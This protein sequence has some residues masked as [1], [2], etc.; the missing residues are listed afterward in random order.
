[1]IRIINLISLT[2]GSLSGITVYNKQEVDYKLLGAFYFFVAPYQMIIIYNKLDLIEKI[3]FN[4]NKRHHSMLL[5]M[6]LGLIIIDASTFGT[7]YLLGNSYA[8]MKDSSKQELK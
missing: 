6:L 5:T 2:L 7:G 8:K 1:M 4:H 3:K